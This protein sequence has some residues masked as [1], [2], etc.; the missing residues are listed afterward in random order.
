MDDSLNE[1]LDLAV[2]QGV[3]VT[4][5]VDDSPASHSNIIPSGVDSLGNA[6]PGGDVIVAMEGHGISSIS[7]LT[8]LLDHYNS[9]EQV[10]LSLIRNGEKVLT[11][12]TLAEWPT[13]WEETPGALFVDPTS[14]KSAAP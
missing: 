9:R 4:G 7:D 14:S 1:S 6:H 12:I 2:S 3:Y 8:L 10:E 11:P 5:V 13:G